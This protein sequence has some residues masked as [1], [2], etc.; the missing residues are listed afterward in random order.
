MTPSDYDWDAD[1]PGREYTDEFGNVWRWAPGGLQFVRT[2]RGRIT[3]DLRTTL[4]AV[5]D[6]INHQASGR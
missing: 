6:D 2:G 4:H 1:D 5:I 3:D